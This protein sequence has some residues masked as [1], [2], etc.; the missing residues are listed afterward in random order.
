[1]GI[2]I[3]YAHMVARFGN[4]VRAT[5]A[6]SVDYRHEVLSML[7]TNPVAGIAVGAATRVPNGIDAVVRNED[8]KCIAFGFSQLSLTED[9]AAC[10][11]DGKEGIV[12]PTL[13]VVVGVL[14]DYSQRTHIFRAVIYLRN[15]DVCRVIALSDNYIP[16]TFA[17]LIKRI[18]LEVEPTCAPEGG[19]VDGHPLDSTCDNKFA[20]VSFVDAY[21]D[22]VGTAIAIEPQKGVANAKGIVGNGT[23]KAGIVHIECIGDVAANT[24]NARIDVVDTEIAVASTAPTE[25]KVQELLVVV[26]IADEAVTALC[27]GASI[28][29]WVTE[30]ELVDEY[31]S[32]LVVGVA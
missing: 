14:H 28:E 17:N 15:L 22:G 26:A 31:G 13:K 3:I 19:V 32:P 12:L 5:I 4:S 7:V 21:D 6:I 10:R 8:D 24:T 27:G 11:F 9:I 20:I 29:D 23:D 1:M 18:N 25:V 16:H 30:V 2:D